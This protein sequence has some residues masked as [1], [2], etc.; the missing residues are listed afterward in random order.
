MELFLG[1]WYTYIIKKVI[2]SLKFEEKKN[3]NNKADG[4]TKI[5]QYYHVSL[6]EE[7]FLSM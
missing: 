4:I 2:F 6:Q 7:C 5:G 1:V 3:N